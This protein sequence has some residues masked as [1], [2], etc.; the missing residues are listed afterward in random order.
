MLVQIINLLPAQW[1]KVCIEELFRQIIIVVFF[2]F[3]IMDPLCMP[4][5]VDSFTPLQRIQTESR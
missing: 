3:Y 2:S 5:Q 4:H 1:G